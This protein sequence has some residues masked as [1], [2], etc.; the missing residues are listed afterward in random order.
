MAQDSSIN[1]TQLDEEGNETFYY[2]IND[3]LHSV[4]NTIISIRKN[5]SNFFRPI[6]YET[7]GILIVLASLYFITVV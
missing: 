3:T 6:Y 7:I 2:I 4:K 1:I 5:V